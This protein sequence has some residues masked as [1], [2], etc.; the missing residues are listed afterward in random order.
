M[1]CMPRSGVY[2]QQFVGKLHEELD[3]SAFR[4]AWQWVVDRH[5]VPRAGIG[6]DDSGE[7]L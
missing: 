2:V 1:R 6:I 5:P 4:L 7:F 3:Y